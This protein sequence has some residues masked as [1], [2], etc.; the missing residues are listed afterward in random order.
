M[1]ASSCG[2]LA[3]LVECGFQACAH[4]DQVR[5]AE[6]SRNQLRLHAARRSAVLCRIEAW[7]S[8]RPTRQQARITRVERAQAGKREPGK[9]L[10][11]T[12]CSNGFNEALRCPLR[13]HCAH[14]NWRHQQ[15]P[16]TH[17]P[18]EWSPCDQSCSTG[19]SALPF[20]RHPTRPQAHHCASNP[21]KAHDLSLQESS[22]QGLWLGRCAQHPTT[23]E[24]IDPPAPP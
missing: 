6:D 4:Q 22:A 18:R 21:H 1:L 19:P 23:C 24:T 5:F 10:E 16:A 3:D 14:S 8:C 7:H 15:T 11:V 17:M 20:R 13:A 2:E 12:T 9:G